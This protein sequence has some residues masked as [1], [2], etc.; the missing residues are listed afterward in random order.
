MR[1]S[2]FARMLAVAVLVAL[3]SI[4]ATA[5]L[6]TQLTRASIEREQG[7]ELAADNRIY[8]ALLEHATKY[9]DWSGVDGV[10]SRFVEANPN[11]RITVVAKDGRTVADVG[12]DR[13]PLPST[14]AAVVDAL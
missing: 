11:R 1:R 12:G 2:V 6:A 7:R 9:R 5:W 8:A 4:A 13:G 10:L 14:A 3:C